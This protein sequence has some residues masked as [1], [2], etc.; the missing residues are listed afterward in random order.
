MEKSLKKGK[1]RIIF[2]TQYFYPEPT[3]KGIKFVKDLINENYNV[4]VVTAFPNYPFGKVYKPY[5]LSLI[6]KEIE[7]NFKITR[8]FV[9]PSHSKLIFLRFINYISFALSSFIYCFFIFY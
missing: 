9:F 7:S 8:L 4:E 1:K 5:K 2:Y 3:I 6:K